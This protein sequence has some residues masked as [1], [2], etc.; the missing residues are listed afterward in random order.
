M[1]KQL[2][3]IGKLKKIELVNPKT[4]KRGVVPG[5]RLAGMILCWD[6]SKN[7]FVIGHSAKHSSQSLGSVKPGVRKAHQKFH[8]AEAS[9]TITAEYEVPVGKVTPIALIDALVYEVPRKVKSPTKNGYLWHHKFGDTKHSGNSDKGTKVMPYLASD[10][11]G[12]LF[13]VRRPGNIYT[14]DSWLRG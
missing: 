7:N 9:R 11:R 6:K 1:A 10:S 5:R 8:G 12:N 4:G 2:L 14:V 3:Y 13:I